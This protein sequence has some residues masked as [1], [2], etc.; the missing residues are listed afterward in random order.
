MSTKTQS[1]N[2]PE[3]RQRRWPTVLLALSLTLNLLGL[4]LIAGAHFRDA[5]DQHRFPP[6]DRTVMRT[7][8]LGPFIDAMPRAARNRMGEMLRERD[9]RI[10]PDRAVLATELREMINALRAEPFDPEGLAALLTAQHERINSRI[11]TAQGVLLQQVAQMSNGERRAF[12]DG[13]ERRFARAI[14]AGLGSN[15]RNGARPTPD[16]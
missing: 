5:R 7:T 2:Q 13:L 8:G 10:M 3:N 9:A 12:A 16:N 15:E 11:G 6:P 14:D 4:G 1:Q